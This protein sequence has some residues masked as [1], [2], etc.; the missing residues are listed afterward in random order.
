MGA[1]R[2]YNG[3]FSL[4]FLSKINHSFLDG[5]TNGARVIVGHCQ[6]G[7][8]QN[9]TI[10]H[11]ADGEEQ[12]KRDAGITSASTQPSPEKVWLNGHDVKAA[13]WGMNCI[14]SRRESVR[15]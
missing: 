3:G 12:R 13:F 2:L 10:Y 11:L 8:R 14:A 1:F 5:N 4:R 9:G 15:E 7:S 6:E